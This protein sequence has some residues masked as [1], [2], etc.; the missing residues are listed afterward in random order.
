MNFLEGRLVTDDGRPYFVSG[1][2]R[3]PVDSEQSRRM[4]SHAGKPIVVGIRPEAICEADSASNLDGE[5]HFTAT[6]L[7]SEVQGDR[8]YH[9]I[10]IRPSQCPVARG[11]ARRQFPPNTAE[12]LRI[13]L[14]QL[15]FFES[16]GKGAVLL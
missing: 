1:A 8:V 6:V 11:K 4:S 10:E 9:R 15:H 3:L 14:K 5:F 7:V 13:D 12:R 16:E 2:L